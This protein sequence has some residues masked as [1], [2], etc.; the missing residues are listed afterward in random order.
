MRK[1]NSLYNIFFFIFI[2]STFSCGAK[3]YRDH[4]TF[5]VSNNGNDL[6]SGKFAEANR[7]K[8]DGPFASIS[9]ARNVV[10]LLKKQG[11]AT[12][13]VTV[14]IRG[15]LYELDEPII[16]TPEDSGTE[17]SIYITTHL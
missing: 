3:N 5:Y 8:T 17:S 16:F 4:I 9:H 6:W 13:P 7:G 1:R 14:F 2:L 11:K 12:K 10:R 15:G